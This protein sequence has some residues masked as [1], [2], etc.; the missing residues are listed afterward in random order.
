MSPPQTHKA[1]RTRAEAR[2]AIEPLTMYEEPMSR[3][4]SGVGASDC[5]KLFVGGIAATTTTEALR[6]HFARYGCI[7]DAVVM[8][9]NGRPR[10]F[11]FVT[12]DAP[13]AAA[14]VLTEQQWLD[15]RLVDV[16]RAVPGERNQERT[17]NK[18][19]VGGLPQD[20]STDD[21][22]AYFSAYGAVADA[23]V[24][25]DRRTSRSR[26]FGF[27]RFSG[28]AQGCAASEAVLRDFSSH[29][30]GGKWVEVKRATPAA[31][32]QAAGEL[33]PN[34]MTEM[35]LTSPTALAFLDT[36]DFGMMDPRCWEAASFLGLTTPTGGCTMGEDM[37]NTPMGSGCADLG[38]GTRSRRGRRRKPRNGAAG[39]EEN[40]FYCDRYDGAFEPAVGSEH[41]GEDS[42]DFVGTPLPGLRASAEPFH[43][44]GTPTAL[45]DPTPQKA[46]RN[47]GRVGGGSSHNKVSKK[48]DV[49][50]ENNPGRANGAENVPPGL[51]AG[52]DAMPMKVAC[53]PRSSGKAENSSSLIDAP[54]GLEAGSRPALTNVTNLGEGFT[55]EDFLSLEVGR[56]WLPTW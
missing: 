10:G 41:S 28:G 25:V 9:K 38:D 30:L 46:P 36:A 2:A 5:C 44:P 29:R 7:V 19:F 6:A 8:N 32:L 26:G 27:V 33:S 51:F 53:L 16:K 50:S 24:M 14:A 3:S 43:M 18:I 42:F 23:V 55:R 4:S 21:L 48:Y 47:P 37:Y 13:A 49:N 54:P 40:A 52:A 20:V 56:P 35:D 31:L 34:G 11:G 22:R 45:A 1:H 39:E 12:F 15:G 17:S